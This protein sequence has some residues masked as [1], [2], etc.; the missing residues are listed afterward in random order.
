MALLVADDLVVSRVRR[1]VVATALAQRDVVVGCA[2][3]NQLSDKPIHV[4]PV[5][6]RI[7]RLRGGCAAAPVRKDTPPRLVKPV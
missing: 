7:V 4:K 3:L 6:P 2:D 1:T 5:N